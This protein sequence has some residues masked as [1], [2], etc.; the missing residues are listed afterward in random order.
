MKRA[1]FLDRDGVINRMVAYPDGFDSPQRPDDV[2]LVTDITQVIKE[3]RS[4]GYQI[5]VVTNQPGVAKGK[6]SLFQEKRICQRVRQLLTLEEAD[7]D[8]YF[9][10][11]HHPLAIVEELRVECECRKPKPG[12]LLNAAKKYQLDLP[13]CLYLGDGEVDVLAGKAVGCKTLIFLHKENTPD[14]VAAA[15]KT[16]ADLRFNSLRDVVAILPK[17]VD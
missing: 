9:C 13:K 11:P 5:I 15:N 2:K 16:M 1:L 12:L 7:W 4:L 14:K 10:C 6:Y 3:A 17:L 8:D